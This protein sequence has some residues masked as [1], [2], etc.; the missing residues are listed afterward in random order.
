MVNAETSVLGALILD[1]SAWDTVAT[2]CRAE[3]FESYQHSKIYRAIGELSGSG[4]P[5]DVVTLDSMLPD[6]QHVDIAA[7]RDAVPTAANVAYYARLVHDE[8]TKRNAQ[9]ILRETLEAT[10][11]LSTAEEIV[12]HIEGRIFELG[13]SLGGQYH[14]VR[15]FIT[16]T[17]EELEERYKAH[18][19]GKTVG[20]S[21]GLTE[22]DQLTGGFRKQDL[23]IVGAR[24]SI[25]KTA[26]GLTIAYNIAEATPAAFFSLEMS[27]ETLTERLLSMAGHI[28]MSKIRNGYLIPADFKDLTHGAGMLYNRK[29]YIYDAANAQLSDLK[30]K[31]RRL[32]KR[33]EVELVVVDYVGLIR[34]NQRHERRHEQV[35]FIARELKQLAR[36]LDV[37]VILLAQLNRHAE[38]KMPSLAELAE[39][40]NLE[41]DA[42]VILLLHRDR[43]SDDTETKC[44]IV[45]ARNGATGEFRLAF[46]RRFTSFHDY[47]GGDG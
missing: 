31:A 8:G 24:A 28:N 45:K 25:G 6:V 38:G 13:E 42:D 7:L 9:R 23:V 20:I 1:N 43:L 27:G 15:D 10:T 34:T 36:E 40:G 21:S 16:P 41:Q 11:E 44:A 26:L 35:G 4:R 14:H 17:L 12:E 29:L 32:V 5:V 19:A 33:E 3:D 39:S 46:Q 47:I 22:L 37:P 2:I 18:I 30:A